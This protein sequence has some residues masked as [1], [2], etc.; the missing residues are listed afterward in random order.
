MQ[1]PRSAPMTDSPSDDRGQAPNPTWDRYAP[2]GRLV[3]MLL[4]SATTT[5]LYDSRAELLWCSDDCERLDLRELIEDLRLRSDSAAQS[6]LSMSGGADSLASGASVFVQPVPG[7]DNRPAG[8]IIVELAAGRSGTAAPSLTASL[9]QPVA[10]CLANAQAVETRHPAGADGDA[11]HP[12]DTRGASV[13]DAQGLELLLAVEGDSSDAPSLDKLLRHCVERLDCVCAAIS[14]P[15]LGLSL[16]ARSTPSDG[17]EPV[18]EATHRHLL[19]WA[20]LNNRPMMVNSVDSSGANPGQ[21]ILAVPVRD[22]GQ[23]V[24]GVIALFRSPMARDFSIVEQRIL[25]VVA[26]RVQS[27]LAHEHDALTGAL[28]R[29]EFERRATALLRTAG[30]TPLALLFLDVDRLLAVNDAFGLTAGD[31]VLQR[32]CGVITARVS[33][34][35]PV[36]RLYADR[37]AVL[38]ND[39]PPDAAHELAAEIVTTVARLGYVHQGESVPLTLSAGIA[40][41]RRN[42]PVTAA[43]ARAELAC[44]RARQAGGNTVKVFADTPGQQ[45]AALRRDL[46][47]RELEQAFAA[48][49]F[50]LVAQPVVSLLSGG[51]RGPGDEVLLRLRESSGALT[52]ADRFIAAATSSGLIAALDRWVLMRVLSALEHCAGRPVDRDAPWPSER[53][54]MLNVSAPSLN[55]GG[56][57]E[58]VLAQLAAHGLPPQCFCLE[59]SEAVALGNLQRAEQVMRPLAEAG[60]AIVLDNF[61]TSLSGLVQLA[62]LPVSVVKLDGNLVRSVISER[63]ARSVLMG[64]ASALT[65]LGITAVAEQVET[66]AI[67]EALVE[68]GVEFGQGFHLGK[69]VP[70][71]LRLHADREAERLVDGAAP[72]MTNPGVEVPAVGR[73][74]ML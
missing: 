66:P 62:R 7:A 53:R 10:Q 45:S 72:P 52:A 12:D 19:A 68:L 1:P 73:A 61:G 8:W 48:R 25:D 51:R 41:I 44:K 67:A 38:L 42:E 22:G 21:K 17:D 3:R 60:C 55:G 34:Q 47:A 49:R 20:Q 23:R 37:F 43:L 64:T 40:A 11:D 46:I 57:A 32:V 15:D 27:A 9:L 74:A 26:R 5:A 14:I 39:C 31:E 35:D 16:A 18:M 50:E 13:R 63:G 33:R 54:V 59:I 69:P 6:T 65:S 29:R 36:S 56:Y 58:F 2:Y 30:D 24:N 70:L 71:S 4:P 28:C